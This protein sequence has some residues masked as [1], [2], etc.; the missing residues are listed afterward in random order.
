MQNEYFTKQWKNFINDDGDWDIECYENSLFASS[1]EEA[2]ENLASIT[3][4][5]ED[6]HIEPPYIWK[7]FDVESKEFVILIDDDVWVECKK[8]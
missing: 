1:L 5:D 7:Y 3:L 6:F 8:M 4:N 2:K